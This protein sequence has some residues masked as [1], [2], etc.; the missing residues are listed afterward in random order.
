MQT[1]HSSFIHRV[2]ILK[3]REYIDQFEVFHYSSATARGRPLRP[4]SKRDNE[5]YIVTLDSCHNLFF[6]TRLRKHQIHPYCRTYCSWDLPAW[7]WALAEYLYII[8]NK[9]ENGGLKLKNSQVPHVLYVTFWF[10]KSGG[11][12]PKLLK[13]GLLQGNKRSIQ[14]ASTLWVV[15]NFF[16]FP[17]FTFVLFLF[18]FLGVYPYLWGMLC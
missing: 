13:T 18:H 7:N 14:R 5:T 1:K 10:N 6:L 15:V 3:L 2:P 11:G 17:F 9:D 12:M 8:R 16:F 4:L